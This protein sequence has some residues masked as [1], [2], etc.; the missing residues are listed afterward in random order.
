MRIWNIAL[1]FSRVGDRA[2]PR[3]RCPAAFERGAYRAPAVGFAVDSSQGG[4]VCGAVV[5]SPFGATGLR[6]A[7][8]EAQDP[9]ARTAER[10]TRQRGHEPRHPPHRPA[11]PAR[12]GRAGWPARL[13]FAQSATGLVLALFMWGHMFFVSSILLGNDAMWTITKMFEGY[14]LFGTAHPGIVS[15][16]VAVIIGAARRARGARRAQVPDQL[17]PVPHVPRPHE[18]DAPRGHDALVLAGGHRLRAVLPRRAPPV[19]DADAA[20]A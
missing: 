15:V 3:R 20:R 1:R 19:P 4:R 12:P 7:Q 10:R 13:D 11:S 5:W 2:A 9:R 18:P 17:P 6:A 16:V 8:S 14:F